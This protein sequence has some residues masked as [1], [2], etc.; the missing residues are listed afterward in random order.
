MAESYEA[1]V[2]RL[3]K[4]SLTHE[5]KVA[6]KLVRAYGAAWVRIRAAVKRLDRDYKQSQRIAPIPSVPLPTGLPKPT[7]SSAWLIQA[8]RG[9]QFQR[10]VERELT[11]FATVAEKEIGAG[12]KWAID[13]GLAAAALLVQSR[14]EEP[15]PSISVQW[16]KVDPRA[17]EE[18]L[19]MNAVDTPL[20]ELLTKISPNGAKRASEALIKGIEQG[21][22]P[23]AVAPE[24]RDALGVPLSRALTISRT[25]MMRAQRTATIAGYR[26]NAE[27]IEG[28]EWVASLDEN[29]CDECEAMNGTIHPLSE[30][31]D[32]HPNCRCSAA[33]VSKSWADIG[34][35]FG[36]DLSGIDDEKQQIE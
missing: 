22:N 17:V 25:E 11:Q 13:F 3:R 27:M 7:G 32:S 14:M 18:M 23:M 1:Q 29:C 31:M 33:P 21:R 19:R 8:N 4:E 30:E 24:I 12:Q 5:R 20:H 34:K 6:S 10:E 26:E 36:F 35:Q 15:P 28:W 9:A 16:G 2:K